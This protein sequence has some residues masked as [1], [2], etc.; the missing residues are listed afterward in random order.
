[1][2]AMLEEGAREQIKT[3]SQLK[4]VNEYQIKKLTLD[5]D[6]L[7]EA[8]RQLLERAIDFENS[9][10]QQ[11]MNDREKSLNEMSIFKE[12][13]MPELEALIDKRAHIVVGSLISSSKPPP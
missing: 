4:D 2:A 5:T 8:N 7:R 12:E 13:L 9:T 1:M 6:E 10:M 3:I 11:Q